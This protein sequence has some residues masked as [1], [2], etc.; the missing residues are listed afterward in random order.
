MGKTLSIVTG[1]T[2]LKLQMQPWH[3]SAA[4]SELPFH[5]PLH[6]HDDNSVTF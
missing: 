2:I 5:P 4:K 6:L 3:Q 1:Q